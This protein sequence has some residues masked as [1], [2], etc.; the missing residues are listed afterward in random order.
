MTSEATL[1]GP[2]EIR[3]L[4][5]E[6]DLTPTKRHG[7]NFVIDPNTVR[8]IV[9]LA[10]LSESDV[11]VEVGPGL[12]SLTLGLLGAC[13][14]VVAIEIDQRLAELLPEAIAAR[15][16]REQIAL[17]LIDQHVVAIAPGT[18]RSI[19]ELHPAPVGVAAVAGG[20]DQ[21]VVVDELPRVGVVEFERTALRIDADV[22][23]GQQRAAVERIQRQQSGRIVRPIVIETQV[24]M[25]IV[26]LQRV[27][28][29]IAA[30][31]AQ[32]VAVERVTLIGGGARSRATRTL[33]PS[34]L[35]VPVDVPR[36]GE[37]V[38]LGAARQAAW[39]LSGDE[40]P[41]VWAASGGEH[42]T[43][44]PTPWIQQRYDRVAAQVAGLVL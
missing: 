24:A 2:A 25:R 13:R 42:V 9:R 15:F 40:R 35:G 5:A 20:T 36:P 4:A 37:Y 8:R 3:K 6:L 27:V 1:L 39:V 34:I 16:E 7:Q 28:A 10:G 44:E 18:L 32:G 38:A 19:V 29:G 11:V 14:A 31:Q 12:G 22:A 30:Q 21:G 43:G 17:A 26:G 41:P 33:A 23:C